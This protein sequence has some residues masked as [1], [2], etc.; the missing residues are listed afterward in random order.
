M[1]RIIYV[2]DDELIGDLV[3]D[4]LIDAGHAVGV[5]PD[6]KAA[7]SIL[8]MKVPDLVILDIG[9]PGMGGIDVLQEMRRDPNLYGIPALMLTGRRGAGDEAIAFHSGATEYLRKPFDPDQLVVIVEDLLKKHDR[10][11]NQ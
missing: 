5:V 4:T 8:K 7:L 2:E 6:G 1:A 3:R 11:R 9:L 10:A